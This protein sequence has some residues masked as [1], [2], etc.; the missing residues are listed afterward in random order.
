MVVDS[1]LCAGQMSWSDVGVEL[2]EQIAQRGLDP[3]KRKCELQY[4]RQLF[5]ELS[6]KNAGR[7]ENCP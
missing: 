7:M 6:I 4:K 3:L 1:L 5:S 2:A